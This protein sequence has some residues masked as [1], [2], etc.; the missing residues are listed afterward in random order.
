M[1]KFFII[2]NFIFFSTQVFADIEGVIY[3]VIDA[4]TVII[5]SE[6]G[7]KYKVRL[8]GIDAPEIKQNYGKE[9][10]RYLSS[11]VL[12]KFLVVTGSKKD[13]YKR[14]LGKL[15]LGGNDINLNLIK[16]G[17]AWHYKRFKNSQDRKDQFLYSN[18]EKYAK[19]NKLGLWSKEAPIAP[20]RWRKNKK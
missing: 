19:V 9:S 15:V 1:L 14:L 13:R 6:E 12:G 10:T 11:M 2:I 16:N 3:R 8:L 7:A 4:D 20:W 5:E 18:A 17:M